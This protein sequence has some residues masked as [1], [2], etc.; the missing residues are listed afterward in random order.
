MGMTP[1]RREEAL[2]PLE[3]AV[4]EEFA[5][6]EDILGPLSLEDRVELL[7]DIVVQ[8]AKSDSMS[9]GELDGHVQ[10]AL[11]RHAHVVVWSGGDVQA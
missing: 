9:Y 8:L 4:D 11:M 2:R 10:V 6:I 7:V 5:A 3:V 1:K